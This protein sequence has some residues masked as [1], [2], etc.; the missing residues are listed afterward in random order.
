MEFL[1][2]IY[3][4]AVDQVSPN[5]GETFLKLKSTGE[6][7][8]AT[9]ISWSE[10]SDISVFGRTIAGAVP[11]PG[12]TGTTKFLREDGTWQAPVSSGGTWGSITG[13]LSSQTDLQ[14]ALNAKQAVG[15]YLRLLTSGGDIIPYLAGTDPNSYLTGAFY[16]AG[17][18]S[19]NNTNSNILSL[20]ANSANIFQL[21]SPYNDQSFYVRSKISNTWYP[22]RKVWTDEDFTFSSINNWNT[23]F[24]WGNHASAG[25]VPNSISISA[26]DHLSGGGQLN[27]DLTLNLRPSVNSWI[28]DNQ[29]LQRLYFGNNTSSNGVILRT[30]NNGSLQYRNAANTIV[31]AVNINGSLVNGTVPWARLSGI[32]STFTPSAHTHSEYVLKS[33]DTM[34]GSLNTTS[35]NL[36]YGATFN[37]GSTK[38][39]LYNNPGVNVL[40][41]RDTTNGQMLTTWER[42]RFLV[43]QNLAVSGDTTFSGDVNLGTRIMSTLDNS[44]LLQVFNGDESYVGSNGRANLTLASSNNPRYRDLSGTYF[45]IWNEKNLPDY[46]NYGLGINTA[47]V[48]D[49]SLHSLTH[50]Q[51]FSH[52]TG[53][54][55]IDSAEGNQSLGIHMNSPWGRGQISIAN[56][57][58]NIGEIYVRASSS[59]TGTTGF[60]A[61]RKLLSESNHSHRTDTANDS[62]Y[63]QRTGDTMTGTLVNTVAQNSWAFQGQTSSVNPSGLWFSGTTARILLRDSSGV[64]KTMLAASGDNSSNVINGNTIWHAGNLTQTSINNWNTAYNWGN[65]A[66]AGYL[67][68]LPGHLLEDHVGA[69]VSNVNALPTATTGRIGY[70]T[71]NSAALNRPV[72]SNNANGVLTMISHSGPYGK[73]IAFGDTEDLYIRKFVNA[74]S[75]SPW[76]KLWHDGNFIP[77]SYVAKSGD[78]MTGSL[79]IRT[80]GLILERAFNSNAI[81]FTSGTDQNHVLWNDHHGGPITRGA[82]GIGFDGIIW[83]T[84]RGIFLK[85]GTGGS[86]N[87][88]VASNSSGNTNDHTVSLYAS[89]VVR[90]QT[91]TSGVNVTGVISAT[92]GNSTNWNTAFGWGNHSTQGYALA[93]GSNASGTWNAGS[94]GITSLDTRAVNDT[95]ADKTSRRI[96]FDFKNN[97]AVGTPPV[98]A[99]GTY[100]HIITIAGWNTNESSGGWP[101]QLSV[102]TL[103]IAYRQATSATTWS[104]WNTF[105]HAG[106]FNP[107]TKADTGGGNATGT[108]GIGISGNAATATILQTTRT[109]NGASFNGLSNIETTEWIHSG[110]DFPNGTLVTSSINYNVTNG[111]PWILE[112][113]GNSYGGRVPFD[114]QLQGYIYYNT[115]INFGGLSNGI[116]L[117]GL[118]A[119]NVGGNL[120]FWWPSQSYWQGFNVRVYTAQS[121]RAQNKVVSITGTTKPAGTKEIA[122]PIDSVIRQSLHST[123]YNSYSPT[124]TGG[125]ASG[126]WGVNI[127]GSVN[128]TGDQSILTTENGTTGAWRGRILSRN[129]SSD[130]SVFIGHHGLNAG[131]FAHNSPLNGWADLYVNTVNGTTGGIVRLPSQVLINGSQAWHAGNLNPSTYIT[132][133]GAQT[134]TGTKTMGSQ[135]ALVANNYGRGVFGLYSAV[136]YQH[137]WS[138][139]AAYKTSDDGA[140]FGNMY[141]LT[142][143]H[144]NIGTGTNQAIAGLS[145]QLQ[146]RTNGTLTAAIG[147]GIWTSGNVTAYSDISVKTNLEKIP[148]ALYKI[149]QINGYTYDRTDYKIDPVTG[150]MP[151]TR[152]AGVVAQE[153]EKVLPEVVCGPE[154]NKSVAYGNMVSLLIEGIKEQQVQIEKMKIEIDN[155]KLNNKVN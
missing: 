117:S 78:T 40:Y 127:T 26:G 48:L 71:F 7:V 113:K 88:I 129:S 111:D 151:E 61:W 37:N 43:N 103:G 21:G 94:L 97:T 138:M 109:I 132:L 155:L 31:W 29:E 130:R 107:A 57:G 24:D 2:K 95:P 146:H 147:T 153:V 116:S 131:V 85:G 20:T 101:T 119:L 152:Q 144:T 51:F 150:E 35:V 105:W 19:P 81:W 14:T 120:C 46:R 56:L 133:S 140:S 45:N 149:M 126:T 100:A 53:Q 23:A 27:S 55:P 112:I 66:S 128:T 92:G 44:P 90:L 28:S 58:S 143:T 47:N 17:S 33:G 42:T 99:S 93:N 137:V 18:N 122:F 83:N 84:Y 15:N 34:T 115:M 70:R 36:S 142:Y 96:S 4:K 38:F 104:N 25:Y 39:L 41:M 106:N 68:S 114:I 73:Q 67:T 121:G 76:R 72:A 10:L 12:G 22:W 80:G 16:S 123:N 145:H 75:F 60:T 77:G 52:S 102:G 11:A 5:Q 82:G 32:P 64:I 6:F 59:N 49:T 139:G 89:N 79:S 110:R 125:G 154:G 74:T 63:V 108:W 86:Q 134:F 30:H 1:N 91:S 54:A 141:G 148:N 50:T 9:A 65:H 69:G 118:V 62:R 98:N 124:L 135:V 3:V 13:T 8:K 136:R 87:L